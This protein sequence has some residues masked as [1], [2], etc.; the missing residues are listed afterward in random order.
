[1][2]RSEAG[3]GCSRRLSF[4]EASRNIG[5]H[6]TMLVTKGNTTETQASTN[7]FYNVAKGQTFLPLHLEVRCTRMLT[8][9]VQSR[10]LVTRAPRLRPV[11]VL[12]FQPSFG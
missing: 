11:G 12:R 7:L 5:P 8:V 3:G 2:E 1:V 6:R 10:P 9:L 4:P